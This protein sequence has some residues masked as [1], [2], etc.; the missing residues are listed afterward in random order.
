MTTIHCGKP[1]R[2]VP[3]NGLLRFF[4]CDV[5]GCNQDFMICYCGE[6]MAK[7][8]KGVFECPCGQKETYCE[9]PLFSFNGVLDA[10]CGDCPGDNEPVIYYWKG[11]RIRTE[12]ELTKENFPYPPEPE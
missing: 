9:D 2:Q 6:Q 4:V 10:D 3:Q 1:V 11:Q 8:K 12:E 5:P 7:D